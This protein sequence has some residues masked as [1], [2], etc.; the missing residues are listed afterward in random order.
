MSL[1]IINYGLIKRAKIITSKEVGWIAVV[2]E[3]KANKSR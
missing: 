2:A 3:S 1:N